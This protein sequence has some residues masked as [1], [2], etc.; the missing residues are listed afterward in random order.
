MTCKGCDVKEIAAN[1]DVEALIAEQLELERNLASFEIAQARITICE[2]C[3]FR[4]NH[5]CTKCGCYYKF[6]ANLSNKTCPA[7]MWAQ[8]GQYI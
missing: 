6:R 2:T 7:G 5:T 8:T 1:V 3:P 4:A